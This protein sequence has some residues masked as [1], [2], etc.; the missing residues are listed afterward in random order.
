MTTESFAPVVHRLLTGALSEGPEYA[1]W[2]THGTTDWLLVNTVAGRGRFG[3]PQGGALMTTEGDLVLYRPGIRHDYGTGDR[4]AVWSLQFAHFNP[5]PEW[6]PLLGWPEVAPGLRRL[7]TTGEAHHRVTQSLAQSVTLG[8]GGLVRAE[9]FAQN[10][11]E[12][13]LLWASTQTPDTRPLDP[14]LL[15]VLDEI[16]GHLA[17]PITVDSL[18]RSAG[19]SASRLSHLFTN[20]L[21]TAPMRFVERSRMLAAEQLLDFT[22]RSIAQVARA[23]GFDDP[24]Y[25]STRFKRCTGLSPSAYRNRTQRSQPPS[26]SARS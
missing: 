21:G 26:L 20:Q 4:A 18:A 24:L 16:D 9:L 12:A 17:E 3:L 6:L 11:F 5:R 19:L 25:F 23:V 7:R 13:A 8:R 1:T 22:G 10:A 15:S 2:R 14:R